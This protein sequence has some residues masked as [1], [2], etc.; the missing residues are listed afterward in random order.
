MSSVAGPRLCASPA[1]PADLVAAAEQ[2]G[3]L[4]EA[5]DR[6]LEADLRRRKARTTAALER[7]LAAALA[8]AW[9][10]QGNAFLGRLAGV[11]TRFTATE[12]ATTRLLE[13][14]R[15]DDWLPLF[16]EVLLETIELFV[17]PIALQTEAAL[18]AGAV[19]AIADL[20]V[21]TSFDLASPEA[22][23]ALRERAATRVAGINATT[24]DDIRRI[25]ANGVADQK[26]Y[27]AIAR[28][29]R[30]KYTQFAVGSP[31][32]HIASR[33]ELVAV[34]EIGD[35]YEAGARGVA[36]RLVGAG[37]T[38]EKQWLDVGDRRVDPVCASNAAEA[39]I[40]IDQAFGSGH[41]Q[42]TAHPGCRCTSQYRRQRA[43]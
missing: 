41:Q 32:E 2:A 21:R 23:E 22:I 35:A 36:D 28:E 7:D 15:E 37:L 8:R 27:S 31:L 3:T 33:A 10:R 40:P 20:R 24:R 19:A 11:A 29:I 6:L 38:M 16:D 25:I 26:S 4:V 18:R 43:G 30:A 12:S 42:P 39:W 5:I 13:A 34:T 1:M 17:G 14:I 9:R